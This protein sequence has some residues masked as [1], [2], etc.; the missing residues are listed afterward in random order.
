MPIMRWDP[1]EEFRFPELLS[2]RFHPLASW[3][4]EFMEW[5]SSLRE[6]WWPK[7][8]VY[9]EGKDLVVKAEVP[10][11]K[12]E[13]ISVTL[14]EGALTIRGKREREEEVE[15]ENYYRMERSFGSFLRSIPVPRGVK[16]SDIQAESSDGVLEVRLKGAAKLGET[17]RKVIP[18]KAVSKKKTSGKK[19]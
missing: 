9:D 1:F 17:A 6:E 4:Q 5:P 13:D 14:E 2:R 11:V 19:K 12:P 8:D 18:V 3:L 15:K 10:G 7:V 16:E